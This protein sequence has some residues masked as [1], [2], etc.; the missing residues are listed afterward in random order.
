MLE[1]VSPK[2]TKSLEHLSLKT[3]IEGDLGVLGHFTVSSTR[4]R[5]LARDLTSEDATTKIRYCTWFLWRNQN[6]ITF[7]KCIIITCGSR[8]ALHTRSTYLCLLVK[9]DYSMLNCLPRDV[10][11]SNLW[12]GLEPATLGKY[13]SSAQ[14]F[15]WAANCTSHFQIC[16]LPCYIAKGLV[17]TCIGEIFHLLKKVNCTLCSP[18]CKLHGL[19]AGVLSQSKIWAQWCIYTS[20]NGNHSPLRANSGAYK[21]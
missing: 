6:I 12:C 1:S 2:R 9:R 13:D 20:I 17:I 7:R 21:D 10:K 16:S 3:V 8:A 14:P 11:L 19:K 4:K 5:K 15:S 18:R